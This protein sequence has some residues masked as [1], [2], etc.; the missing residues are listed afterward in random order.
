MRSHYAGVRR[1]EKAVYED[2]A[3][4]YELVGCRVI[5]FAQARATMQTPGIPDLKVYHPRSGRTWWHE[6]KAEEGRQ[7]PAQVGFQA[8]AETCGERVVVGGLEEAI[9]ALREL[10]IVLPE[11]ERAGGGYGAGCERVSREG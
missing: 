8:L 9:T 1:P 7:S 3:N 2:V 10:G 11:R 4:A 6:V 5:R